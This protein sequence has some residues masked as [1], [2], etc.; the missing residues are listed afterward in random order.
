MPYCRKCDM[1]TEDDDG[2]YFSGAE[3]EV[4]AADGIDPVVERCECKEPD[5]AS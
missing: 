1:P 4:L 3:A 5:A 2:M